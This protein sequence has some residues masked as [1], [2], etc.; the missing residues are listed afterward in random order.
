MSVGSRKISQV[1]VNEV[2]TGHCQIRVATNSRVIS[3][4]IKGWFER[5]GEITKLFRLEMRAR[6][7]LS[8]QGKHCYQLNDTKAKLTRLTPTWDI[9]T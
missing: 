1:I 4:G 9:N 8:F 7:E 3:T 6:D 5:R 2:F